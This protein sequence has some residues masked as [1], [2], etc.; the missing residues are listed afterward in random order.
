[1]DIRV[2][3]TTNDLDD[4][5]HLADM[6]E[7]LVPEAFALACSFDETRNINELDGRGDNSLR[8]GEGRKPVQALVRDVNDAQVR[9]DRTEGEVCSM[10]LAAPSN[11][12]E[13]RGFADVWQPDDTGFEHKAG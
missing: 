2:F 4:G 11:R 9:L 8:L 5:V 10:G 7:K 12:I 1:M 3:E 13:K 6:A